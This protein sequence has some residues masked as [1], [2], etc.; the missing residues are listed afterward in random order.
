MV[1]LHDWIID[2][3]KAKTESGTEVIVV[4]FSILTLPRVFLWR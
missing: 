3:A 2:A 1:S 4:N